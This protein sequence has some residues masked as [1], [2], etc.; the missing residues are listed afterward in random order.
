VNKKS[1]NKKRLDGKYGGS[2]LHKKKK[3]GKDALPNGMLRKKKKEN[4]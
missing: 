2:V 3:D 1:I 4:K